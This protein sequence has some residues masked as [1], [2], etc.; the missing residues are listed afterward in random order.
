MIGNKYELSK[1]SHV[2]LMAHFADNGTLKKFLNENCDK[3]EYRNCKLCQYK[4]SLPT[5]LNSFLWEANSVFYKTGGWENSKEEYTKIINGIK[6]K[7]KYIFFNMYKS[8]L[9]SGTQLTRND[10]GSGLIPFPKGTEQYG[11]ISWRFKNELNDYE[12]SRQN[13]QYL[14]AYLNEINKFNFWIN[15]CSLFG[16]LLIAFSG[17]YKRMDLLSVKLLGMFGIAVLF[18]AF[19]TAGISAP[20]ERYQARINWLIVLAVLIV[21]VKNFGVLKSALKELLRK[22]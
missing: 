5:N 21:V 6:S 14:R 4:D 12:N 20:S 15:I 2:F 3:E 18:N 13:T 19:F 17:I 22:E 16:L 1:G 10:I 11:Q 7:P 9:Y 8:L